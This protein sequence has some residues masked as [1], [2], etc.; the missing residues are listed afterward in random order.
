MIGAIML[1]VGVPIEGVGLC[2]GI[3]RLLDMSRTVINVS[4]DMTIAACVARIVGRTDEE[5]AAAAS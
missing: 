5:L 2:M 3:D 4:G 1:M